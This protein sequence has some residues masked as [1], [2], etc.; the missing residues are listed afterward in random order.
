M[1]KIGSVKVSAKVEGDGMEKLGE[2]GKRVQEILQRLMDNAKTPEALK[3][4]EVIRAQ[5]RRAHIKELWDYAEVPYRLRGWRFEKATW[6]KG[7]ESVKAKFEALRGWEPDAEGRGLVLEGD[8]GVGKTFLA[9]CI[10]NRLIAEKQMGVFTTTFPEL[11]DRLSRGE[12]WKKREAVWSKATNSTVLLIDDIPRAEVVGKGGTYTWWVPKLW[13]LLDS[14]EKDGRAT[15]YT[16]NFSRK[17]VKELLGMA[18]YSR[19]YDHADAVKIEGPN[20]RSGKR[21][22]KEGQQELL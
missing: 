18:L 9:Y 19:I 17:S 22:E 4:R 6:P 7:T 8:V 10:V 1:E 20:R 12:Y 3:R 16:S 13:S 14:R 15:I 11:V 2:V 21:E 5:E